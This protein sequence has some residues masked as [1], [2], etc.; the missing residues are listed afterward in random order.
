[1][2]ADRDGLRELALPRLG[3]RDCSLLA[4]GC[5]P[6]LGGA[7]PD[8][9]ARPRSE[10]RRNV[11]GILLLRQQMVGGVE[12]DEALGMLCRHEDLRGVVDADR[13]VAGR[14]EDEERFAELVD[15]LV[16]PLTGE[17]GEKVIS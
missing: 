8:V 2:P 13:R 12:R 1:M 11:L 7:D 17:S 3:N 15:R 14:V 6:C 4:A 10:H 5:G 16:R 9:A